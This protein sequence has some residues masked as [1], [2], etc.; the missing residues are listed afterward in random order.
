MKQAV[1]EITVETRGQGLYDITDTVS[2]W[3]KGCGV[4]TGLL[5]VFCRHTSAS[6]LIQENTDPTVRADLQSYFES[7]APE[8]EGLYA[9]NEEGAD[10]MPAHLKTALTQT[11]LTVPIHNARLVLGMW[12][13]LYLFEHRRRQHRR[14]VV[15]HLFG[16]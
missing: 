6:L 3:A 7:L 9:H 11:T 14:N 5:T 13:A 4:T 2:Q 12:Q 1:Q 16:E 15:L 10:D 8:N